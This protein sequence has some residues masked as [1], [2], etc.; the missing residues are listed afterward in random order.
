VR[1]IYP[2]FIIALRAFAAAFAEDMAM[3]RQVALAALVGEHIAHATCGC[4]LADSAQL[5]HRSPQTN[6][7]SNRNEGEGD[8]KH[9]LRHLHAALV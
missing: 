1:D 2:H 4:L 7:H 9:H 8:A 5:D 6:R 3:H